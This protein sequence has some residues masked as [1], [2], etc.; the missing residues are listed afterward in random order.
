MTFTFC[1][2]G[3]LSKLPQARWGPQKVN[4]CE[5]S[6]L[7]FLKATNSVNTVPTVSKQWKVR[8]SAMRSDKTIHLI[9]QVLPSLFCSASWVQCHQQK[10]MHS[11]YPPVLTNTT[12]QR[13][14]SQFAANHI[15]KYRHLQSTTAHGPH[16]GRKQFN[17]AHVRCHRSKLIAGLLVHLESSSSWK[18]LLDCNYLLAERMDHRLHWDTAAGL[19]HHGPCDRQMHRG[20]RTGN[21]HSQT[22]VPWTACQNH[23]LSDSTINHK[24]GHIINLTA[25]LKHQHIERES[26]NKQHIYQ[27]QRYSVIICPLA[28]KTMHLDICNY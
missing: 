10:I 6:V 14:M 5:L 21:C 19:G 15:L 1:L 23:E 12:S 7:H 28:Q 26:T 22:V 2:S 3:P 18:P 16:P 24:P 9:V 8:I 11:N 4:F 20:R 27:H 25:S 17:T 13:R